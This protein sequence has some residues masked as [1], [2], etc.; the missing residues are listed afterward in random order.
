MSRPR[1]FSRTPHIVTALLV[2]ALALSLCAPAEAGRARRGPRAKA[3]AAAVVS[4]PAP[5]P[6]AVS[7][8]VIAVDPET[9]QL[10]MPTAAQLLELSAAER[11]G[12]LRTSAGLSEVR[13]PDGSWMVDLQ[14]RFMEFSLVGLDPLGRTWLLPVNEETP[15]RRLLTQPPSAPTPAAEER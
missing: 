9:G 5:A 14:G 10:G 12:L 8:A 3:K 2:A 6:P 1:P 7:G 4:Q 15:L 13:L 11:N